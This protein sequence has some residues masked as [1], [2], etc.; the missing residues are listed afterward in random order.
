MERDLTK[1][2]KLAIEK[3]NENWDFRSFLKGQSL[4]KI[5]SIV[6]KLYQKISLEIDCKK[7][8][9][10]CKEMQPV[11]D[12]EDIEKLTKSLDISATQ[13]KT[14]FLKKDTESKNYM[15]KK[16]PCPFLKSNLCSCYAFRP[17]DCVSY[18][19]LHKKNFTCRLIGV[20]ENYAICPIVFNVYECLKEEVWH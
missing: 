20:I 14:R 3:E 12:S 6:E 7:C 19:H 17:K 5:D 1:I 11:L 8:T 15:F 4:K 10:C 16:K 13:F 18:L 9:N 2:K